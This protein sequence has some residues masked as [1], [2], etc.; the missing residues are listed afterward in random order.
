MLEILYDHPDFVAINKPHDLLVHRTSIARD[1]QECALQLLRDQLGHS[2]HPVHRLDR[3]TGGVLLFGKS[4]RAL[5]LISNQFQSRS[6]QKSY[7]AI[8]RGFTDP[9]GIIDYPL[10]ND[11]CKTQEAITHYWTLAK[12]ELNFPSAHHSTSRYS[13]VGLLP[14]TGRMHQLRKHMAHILHPI[15]ADRPY[16]CNK[17]N[18]MFKERFNMMTMLLHASKLTFEW[19][20]ATIEIN[21]PPQAEFMRMLNVLKLT[22]GSDGAV[23][24]KGI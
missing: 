22:I 19:E 9:K 4:R 5:T 8:V 21:A 11:S 23:K 14:H 13:L 24:F 20:G 12:T 3:K 1:V 7:L 16:G 18:K 15:V 6:V 10:K 2:V 17:Q